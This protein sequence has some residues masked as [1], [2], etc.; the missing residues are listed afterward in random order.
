MR[1]SYVTANGA[2]YHLFGAVTI[3]EGSST[4]TV[5]RPGFFLVCDH[6]GN[7]IDRV[8]GISKVIQLLGRDDAVAA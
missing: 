5:V 6:K 3:K 8:Y 7:K 2:A 1:A 4:R